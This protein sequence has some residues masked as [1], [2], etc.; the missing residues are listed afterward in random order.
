MEGYRQP[1]HVHTSVYTSLHTVVYMHTTVCTSLH[2]VVCIVLRS[3][4]SV[5]RCFADC[6]RAPNTHP[7]PKRVPR[8]LG[9]LRGDGTL[10]HSMR[11]PHHGDTYG[12]IMGTCP[13]TCPLGIIARP[14][15]W[16]GQAPARACSRRGQITP[17]IGACVPLHETLDSIG[18]NAS[19][20]RKT[21][22]LCP[23][24]C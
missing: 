24:F 20:I 11:L 22:P 16:T 19:R 3:R 17:L 12:D 13:F 8:G 4:A 2:T 10:S 23:F 5:T 1:G 15:R 21:C 18:P 14:S 9:T 7:V 6:E